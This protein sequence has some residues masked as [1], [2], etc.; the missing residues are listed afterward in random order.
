MALRLATEA[1]GGH[2]LPTPE[3]AAHLAWAKEAAR[4]RDAEQAKEAEQRAKE[5]ALARVRELEAELA[6]RG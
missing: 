5:A 2:L 6:R 3:E 4:A 1:Q